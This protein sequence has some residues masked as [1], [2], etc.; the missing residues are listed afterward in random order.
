MK[1]VALGAE[2]LAEAIDVLSDAFGADPLMHYLFDGD[3]MGTASLAG[4]ACAWRLAVGWPVLGVRAEDGALLGVASL[5]CPGESPLQAASD[6]AEQVFRESVTP[7]AWQRY[8]AYVDA[9]SIGVPPGRCHYLGMIGVAS[10]VRGQGVGKVLID[11]VHALSEEDEES[12]GVWLD[13]E[14]PENVR[15]YERQGYRILAVNP[16]GP[17]AVTL[18]FHPHRSAARTQTV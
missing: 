10:S 9:S 5:S 14:R 1:I 8:L 3:P 17:L 18:M 16:L 4:Y 11:A 2:D 6:A 12:T 13:T 15:W 7:E